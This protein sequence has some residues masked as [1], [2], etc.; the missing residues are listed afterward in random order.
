MLGVE[1]LV[2][3]PLLLLFFFIQFSIHSKRFLCLR[4]NVVCDI[5][6]TLKCLSGVAE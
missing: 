3:P 2:F 4:D 6:L 5:K 1:S